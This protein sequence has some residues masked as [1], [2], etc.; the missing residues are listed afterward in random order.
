MDDL[1]EVSD[2]FERDEKNNT[3]LKTYRESV[4]RAI[5][6]LQTLDQWCDAY[7]PDIFLP[8]TSEDWVEH[9][10][11]LKGSNRSGSAAA[12]DCMRHVV[13]GFKKVL[14]E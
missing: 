3:E 10:R 12:A 11:F 14:H 2:I 5:N 9:H 1:L 13:N 6:I 4:D 8:M 7:P